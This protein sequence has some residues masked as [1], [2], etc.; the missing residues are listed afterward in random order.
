MTPAGFCKHVENRLGWRPAPTRNPRYKYLAEGHKVTAKIADNPDLFTW[1]NLLAAVEL[2]AR[3][4][5]PRSPSGVFG[6]VPR[7][8][9]LLRDKEMDLNIDVREASR[10]EAERGDPDGWVEVFAR[11]V[12][13][14]RVRAL[15]EWKKTRRAA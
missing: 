1:P 13:V 7:A 2:L 14:Y 15:T 5:K 3:E 9:D 12:G 10:I 8:L 4:R 11:A 6:H